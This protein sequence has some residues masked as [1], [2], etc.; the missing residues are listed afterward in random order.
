[1]K[2]WIQSRTQKNE[3]KLPLKVDPEALIVSFIQW[4]GVRALFVRSYFSLAQESCQESGRLWKGFLCPALHEAEHYQE[5]V[6]RNWN[7]SLL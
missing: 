7:S 4:H 5:A 6:N 3:G 2:K 1:M